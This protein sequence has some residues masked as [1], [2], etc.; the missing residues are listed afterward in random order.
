MRYSDVVVF[1][2]QMFALVVLIS[3]MVKG[4][5]HRAETD[6]K[7][8]KENHQCINGFVHDKQLGYWVITNRAC[9]EEL[10]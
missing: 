6:R 1:L 10:P 2:L 8:F 3:I 5:E 7:T 9:I 4:C